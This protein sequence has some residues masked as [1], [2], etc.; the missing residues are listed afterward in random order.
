[1]DDNE[2]SN[3]VIHTVNRAR[4]V[5]LALMI[6]GMI[7][8]VVVKPAWMFMF[9][10]LGFFS[11]QI[12]LRIIASVIASQLTEEEI[13]KLEKIDAKEEQAMV[14]KPKPVSE[15]TTA[16]VDIMGPIIGTYMNK[17]IYAFT[18]VKAPNEKETSKFTY[19]APAAMIQGVPQIPVD[20]N[21][22]FACVEGILYSKPIQ[23]K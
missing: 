6:I 19:H 7:I 5:W 2:L 11:Y 3:R 12:M 9:I 1:M 20:P 13:S 16:I 22:L 18:M 14:D 10:P 8:T 21:I 4:T 15:V 17:P 23:P